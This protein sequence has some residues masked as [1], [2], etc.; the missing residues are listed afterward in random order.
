MATIESKAF[1]AHEENRKLAPKYQIGDR[2]WMDWY[3]KG[4]RQ[5]MKDNDWIN[6]SEGLPNEH[7]VVNVMLPDGRYESGWI[8]ENKEWAMNIHPTHWKP[9]S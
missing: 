7:E 2:Y 3:I 8:T 1:A 9:I 6:V 5:C 4:Y